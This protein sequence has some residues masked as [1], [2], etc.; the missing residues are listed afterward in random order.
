MLFVTITSNTLKTYLIAVKSILF[1]CF[2]LSPLKLSSVFICRMIPVKVLLTF[3]P[4]SSQCQLLCVVWQV[5]KKDLFHLNEHPQVRASPSVLWVHYLSIRA[6]VLVARSLFKWRIQDLKSWWTRWSWD[7]TLLCLWPPNQ[8][9]ITHWVFL[10]S[11]Q[12]C[13]H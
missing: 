4:Y 6:M 9:L 3:L 11:I 13:K 5:K 1:T 12:Q 2:Y 8:P 7:L 10:P